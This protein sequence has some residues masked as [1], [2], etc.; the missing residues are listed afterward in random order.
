[1]NCYP[2]NAKRDKKIPAT[3]G[4]HCPYKKECDIECKEIRKRFLELESG[5]VF[6]NYDRENLLTKK[7]KEI[8]SHF[9]K[10]SY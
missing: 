1:M 10:P 6:D 8:I 9:I 4:N 3:C 2:K 7:E 5:V